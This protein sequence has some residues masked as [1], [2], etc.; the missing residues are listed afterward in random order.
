MDRSEI[1]STRLFLAKA[2][3]NPVDGTLALRLTP[4]KASD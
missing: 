2:S 3:S 1:I 4:G